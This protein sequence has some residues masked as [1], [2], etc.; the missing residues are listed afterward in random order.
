MSELVRFGVSIDK[1]LID[2]FDRLISREGYTNRSEALRDLIRDRLV[3][4]EEIKE[5]EMFGT[6]TLV[7]DHHARGLDARLTDI[8]HEYAGQVV[9]AVHVHINHDNCLQV[10]ILRGTAREL[11][12]LSGRLKA[13]KGVKHATLSMTTSGEE[14]A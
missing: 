10:L 8:Q 13:L 12:G 11:R 6:L 4:E 1:R 9:S 14:L 2:P 7:Y 3:R 5:G